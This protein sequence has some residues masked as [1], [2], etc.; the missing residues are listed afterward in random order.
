MSNDFDNAMKDV[1][2]S[3][4][5]LYSFNRRV[6]DLMKY[7][8]AKLSLKYSGGYP[9][10]SNASPKGG[11]G[12]LDFWGWDWLNLYCYEFHFQ[13]VNDY[14]FSIILQS[15]TGSWDAN[16]DAR[17]IK[18]YEEIEN[19]ETRLIFVISKEYWEINFLLENDNLK[20]SGESE[21]KVS[22]TKNEKNYMLCKSFDISNF[23]D[24]LTTEK[25]LQ[26]YIDFLNRENIPV[27]RLQE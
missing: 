3:F 2:A 21:F 8:E 6:L 20:S 12:Q 14:H 23:K 10:F 9:R 17:E 1:R 7:I 13:R 5:L 11:K 18:K 26:A 4:R 22:D 27:M 15:D 16:V 19:S 25:T 24:M